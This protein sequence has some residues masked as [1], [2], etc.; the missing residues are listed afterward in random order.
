[1]LSGP[2]GVGWAAVLAASFVAAGCGVGESTALGHVDDLP[3]EVADVVLSLP[4]ESVVVTTA[5]TAE[6]RA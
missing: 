3:I 4:V 5:T 2:R 1:M 6:A